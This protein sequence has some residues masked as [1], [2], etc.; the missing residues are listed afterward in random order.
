MSVFITIDDL[1]LLSPLNSG[2]EFAV[3][4]PLTNATYKIPLTAISLPGVP[5]L[6]GANVF[7]AAGSNIFQGGF[8]VTGGASTFVVSPVSAGTLNNTAIGG[9]T[10]ASGTF[11][12]ITDKSSTNHGVAVGG[13]NTSQ[14]RYTG[15]GSAGDLLTS[16][17]A[18]SDP[19]FQ[20][21]PNIGPGVG[22]PF[23]SV[24]IDAKGRVTAASLLGY[25][26]GNQTITLSGDVTGSGAT[27]ISATLAT[28]NANI[29]AFNHLTVNGKGLVTAASNLNYALFDATNTWTAAQNLNNQQ[30][31]NALLF[32]YLEVPQTVNA[33]TGSTSIS[34][35]GGNIT[36]LNISASTT[37]TFT[38]PPSSS[39]VGS[40]TI[41]RVHNNSG[42]TWTITWPASVKWGS[43]ASAPTLTQTANSVDEIVIRTIDGG[44]TYFASY[45][46]SVNT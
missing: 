22:G 3:W 24:S 9:T 2:V 27:S 20:P 16:T 11:T 14:L 30:I 10:S 44:T 6:A 7:T 41:Y 4:D 42:T 12:S 13:G 15:T 18:T 37:I 21:L 45:K 35:T 36:I 1:P 39:L 8:T 43:G 19:T 23:N 28:V 5:T 34:L 38:N 17:G 26:T 40:W 46:L 25:I 33:T 29:G 32:N 31:Q